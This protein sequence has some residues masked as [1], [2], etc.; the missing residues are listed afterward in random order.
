VHRKRHLAELAG[1]YV[2]A[3]RLI[4]ERRPRQRVLND[5]ELRAFW[6][7]T[8][9]MDYPYASCLRMLLLTGQR[10]SEVAEARWGEFD[11]PNKLWTVPPER[12]KSDATHLVPLSDDVMELLNEL[13]RWAGGDYL[14]SARGGRRPVAAFSGAKAQLDE[15]M[16]EVPAWVIHDLRRTVRTRLSEL[17]VPEHVAELVIGHARKGLARIYDQ[18]RYADEMREALQAWAVRLRAIVAA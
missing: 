12:F 5:D 11:L 17:R 16:G 4:G 10:K 15:L 7:A 3:K 1:R 9:Q 8:G 14:F 13:P 18:H 2:S 6:A